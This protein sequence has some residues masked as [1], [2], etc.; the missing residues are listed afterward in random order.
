MLTG[1]VAGAVFTSPAVGSILAAIRA[2]TQAGSGTWHGAEWDGVPFLQRMAES[3]C[4]LSP[5]SGCRRMTGL[6]HPEFF[7]R[8]RK[9]FASSTASSQLGGCCYRA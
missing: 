1:V 3:S 8:G 5:P 9:G 7:S 4:R 2:V 6:V